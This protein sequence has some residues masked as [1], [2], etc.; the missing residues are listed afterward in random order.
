MCENKLDNLD[1]MDKLL[2]THKLLKL[3]Q[4]EIGNHIIPVV[5]KKI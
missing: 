5:S 3:T 2:E 1:K 4:E